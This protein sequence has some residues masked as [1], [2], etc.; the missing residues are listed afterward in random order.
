MSYLSQSIRN[1]F[2]AWSSIRREDSSNGAKIIDAFA[3]S[4]EN[5]RTDYKRLYKQGS[6][7]YCGPTYEPG[8]L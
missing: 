8:F 7:I 6:G 2:P 1:R 5:L 3:A 4:L